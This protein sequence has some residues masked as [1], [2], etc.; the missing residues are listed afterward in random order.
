M[1][2]VHLQELNKNFPKTQEINLSQH[3]L[4]HM[5]TELSQLEL[6]THLRYLDLGGN[7]L[8][9]LPTTLSH[10]TKLTVLN[11]AKNPFKSIRCILPV[12]EAMSALKSLSITCK[13]NGEE[14]MVL[15]ALPQLRV[16]N[17]NLL[18][19][20]RQGIASNTYGVHFEEEDKTKDQHTSFSPSLPLQSPLSE[21]RSSEFSLNLLQDYSQLVRDYISEVNEISLLLSY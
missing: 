9:Y 3:G 19:F 5:D 10:C 20:R 16:L 18:Q 8:M 6:F 14:N 12:L 21:L 11:I 7:Q 1:A 2:S 17:G 15:Q 4:S 13:T